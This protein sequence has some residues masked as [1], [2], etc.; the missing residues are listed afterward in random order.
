MKEWRLYFLFD[1]HE[2]VSVMSNKIKTNLIDIGIR[3]PVFDIVGD[4]FES[5]I[6][7]KS[8]AETERFPLEESKPLI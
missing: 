8:E 7:V 5:I 6:D 2:L 3:W 1:A 4:I